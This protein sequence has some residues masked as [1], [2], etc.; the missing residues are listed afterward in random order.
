MFSSHSLEQM[1][2]HVKLG[3]DNLKLCLWHSIY[4]LISE[5]K[6]IHV[7]AL[8]Q[9]NVKQNSRVGKELRKC[10][11]LLELELVWAQNR[12]RHRTD[13]NK[14]VLYLLA[15][16]HNNTVILPSNLEVRT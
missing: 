6:S 10:L 14:H 12:L 16:D 13:F 15:I 7:H 8:P 2:Q 9:T 5:N 11:H 4:S 1:D 3:V